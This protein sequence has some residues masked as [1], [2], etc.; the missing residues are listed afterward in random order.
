VG[1]ESDDWARRILASLDA[2]GESDRTIVSLM[3]IVE[4]AEEEFVPGMQGYP[5]EGLK[6]EEPEYDEHVWTSPKNARLI[7]SEITEAL[8]GADLNNSSLYRQNAAAY[9][10]KL[11]EL[12]KAFEAVVS[13]AQRKTLIFGDRFP[14]RYM[15]EAYGLKYYAAF[16]GCSS[17]TEAAASTIAFLIDKTREEHIPVVF[18]IEFSNGK[19][20][21]AICESTG[22]KN[23]LLHSCHNITHDDFESG[24]TYL[25]LMGRN[26]ENL[27]MALY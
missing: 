14:F 23:L 16:P 17:E 10:E 1:G 24:V 13:E 25:E 21:D 18:H 20:A 11:D 3:D 2:D 22:A 15:F 12:D 7:V 4:A 6:A 19:I 26:V 9:T 8:C 5:G 27:K